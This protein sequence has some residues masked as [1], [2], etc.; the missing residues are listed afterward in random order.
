MV[1]KQPQAI[2]PDH[3]MQDWVHRGLGWSFKPHAAAPPSLKSFIM[4]QF[5]LCGF[6]STLLPQMK[7]RSGWMERT[8]CSQSPAA[9]SSDL[10][11]SV[12]FSWTSPT[13]DNQSGKQ[14]I[15]LLRLVAACHIEI[16]WTTFPSL[17]SVEECQW[18]DFTEATVWVTACHASSDHFKNVW[19]V[20]WRLCEF[21][22]K[23]THLLIIA[24]APL[25]CLWLLLAGKCVKIMR[26]P[27]ISVCLWVWLLLRLYPH[28]AL[29]PPL[30]KSLVVFR[31]LLISLIFWLKD[32]L[33]RCRLQTH[34]WYSHTMA[35]KQV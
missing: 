9:V 1:N 28:S 19:R 29:T 15:M 25:I 34:V 20:R 10:Y 12:A 18:L 4:F 3:F 5:L 17:K 23:Q 7:V 21:S 16:Q 33:Q 13:D 11:T 24:S 2:S 14:K 22:R 35:K 30:L 27:L 32:V 26:T 6:T 31:T 8:V